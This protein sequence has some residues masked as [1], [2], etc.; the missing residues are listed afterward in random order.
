[1][2]ISGVDLG[3]TAKY[4]YGLY[5]PTALRSFDSRSSRLPNR[6]SRVLGIITA[7]TAPAGVLCLD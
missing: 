6:C 1:M 7:A 2:S 3:L 5:V 4:I